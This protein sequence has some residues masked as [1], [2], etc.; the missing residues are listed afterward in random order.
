MS[1][2]F[3][4]GLTIAALSAGDHTC[5]VT[6]VGA[7]YCWGFNSAG[8]LGDGTTDRKSTPV[9]VIMPAGVRFAAVSAGGDHTCGLTPSGA[10]YCWGRN[11]AGQLGDG[12]R[13]VDRKRVPEGAPAGVGF[14]A[15]IL[16]GW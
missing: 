12:T 10:A 9:L 2:A 16:D 1:V 4:I 14:G 7:S 8:Q 3:R 5:A 13:L 11:E 15:M 6:T